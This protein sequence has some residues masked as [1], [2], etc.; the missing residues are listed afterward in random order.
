MKAA[1]AIVTL[2]VFLANDAFAAEDK[3]SDGCRKAYA[4]LYAKDN[5]NMSFFVGSM[6]EDGENQDAMVKAEFIGGLVRRCGGGENLCGFA[7]A[8]DDADIFLKTIVG[9]DG[10]EKKIRLR[11]MSP[12]F[13]ERSTEDKD[14]AQ[15]TYSD[16]VLEKFK[17]A[18]GSDQVVIFQGHA[19]FGEGPSFGTYAEMSSDSLI[20]QIRSSKSKP[21]ILGMIVCNGEAHYGNK[22]H[23]AAPQAGLVLTRQKTLIDDGLRSAKATFDSL[24]GQKCENHFVEAYRKATD[25]YYY[26]PWEF[27]ILSAVDNKTPQISN[28]F[29]PMKKS[30]PD[31]P[32]ADVLW[33][34]YEKQR[35]VYEPTGT[36]R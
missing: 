5:V 8:P 29:G 9:P 18:L 36:A 10:K 28:F 30:F 6:Q 25:F 2:T 35:R 14:D 15:D 31:A 27:E 23:A 34:K 1:W 24:L 26:G 3:A 19:N 7:R 21:D 20:Q 12:H 33:E 4:K 22:L 16:Q 11:V 13:S 32:D 17:E